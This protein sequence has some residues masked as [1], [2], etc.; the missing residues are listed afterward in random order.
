MNY[1]ANSYSSFVQ[2]FQSAAQPNTV[3]TSLD[4]E[5]SSQAYAMSWVQTAQAGSF[6]SSLE[7]VDAGELQSTAT[8]DANNGR[9][10]TAA[11]FDSSGQVNLISCGW[12]EDTATVYEAKTAIVTSQNIASTGATL[13]AQGYVISAFGG[14]DSNGYILIG[15]RVK[16]DSLPRPLEISIGNT[17][18]PATNPDNAYYTTV[19]YFGENDY[20]VL[21]EQ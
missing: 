1:K 13:A 20:T 8:N 17:L 3:I 5:P 16:G 10:I 19:V 18:T 11:S 14:N 6:T 7:V 2:D 15:I 21:S 9:V 12:S 4:L